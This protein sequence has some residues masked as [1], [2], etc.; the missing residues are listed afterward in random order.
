M[1]HL[2]LDMRKGVKRKKTSRKKTTSIKDLITRTFKSLF[3]F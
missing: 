1:R 2:S 3:F